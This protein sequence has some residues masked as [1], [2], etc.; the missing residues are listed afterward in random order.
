[1]P[2]FEDYRPQDWSDF[3]GN[4]KARDKAKLIADRAW[5]SHKPFALWVD[6]PSGTGKTT[7][8][9]LIAHQLRADKCM[10]VIELD[11]PDCDG[12]AVSDLRDKL[13]LRS[14]SGGF[15]VVIINEAHNMSAKGVQLWLTLL[16]KLPTKTA[17]VFTTTEGRGKD[18]LFGAF[19]GP[20]KSRCVGLSLTNQGLA[21]SFAKRAQE[22]AEKEGLGGADAKAYLRLVQASKNNMRA[23]LS[24]IEGFEMYRDP[25]T[26][27]AA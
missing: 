14:W 5:L 4:D 17:V 10:D 16:E 19:D 6:G 26:K 27:E 15:R 21:E 25:D 8:A 3:I 20:L 2:L 11:G 13:N 22:I 23:V 18:D 24:A 1:M 7:L 9:H 12:R